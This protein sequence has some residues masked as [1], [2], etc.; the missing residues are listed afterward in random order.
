MWRGRA[1]GGNGLA[2]ARVGDL[3]LDDDADIGAEEVRVAQKRAFAA[4][5]IDDLRSGT[6]GG[7][8]FTSMLSSA[9]PGSSQKSARS[10]M[11]PVVT[12]S[13]V[14]GFSLRFRSKRDW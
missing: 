13:S 12:N 4:Q 3:E 5:V 1:E 2:G 6:G 14:A 7:V 8:E 10:S 11:L 9:S